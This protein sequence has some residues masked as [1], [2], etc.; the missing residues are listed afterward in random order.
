M[1]RCNC[2][3]LICLI[4]WSAWSQSAQ[5][6]Y[7][8]LHRRAWHRH[9]IRQ[10]ILNPNH[11]A[12]FPMAN[13]EDMSNL[14]ADSAKA[15]SEHWDVAYLRV[16]NIDVWLNQMATDDSKLKYLESPFQNK[17]WSNFYRNRARFFSHYGRY[18]SVSIDPVIDF[19]LGR[20]TGDGAYLFVNRR[21]IEVQ[22]NLDQRWSV[23]S[24]IVETQMNSPA[25]VNDYI[26]LYN[27]HP[28]AGFLKKYNS[29]FFKIAHAYDFLLAEGVI[30]YRISDHVRVQ[31]GHGRHF[32]GS[33]MRS[34]LLSDF[35]PPMFF[36]R[37]NTQFWKIHYQNIYAELSPTSQVEPFGVAAEEKKYFTAHYLSINLL[38]QW[39]VG[40]FESV[41][42]KRARQYEWQYLNPVILYRFVEQSL[43][44]P[45]NVF[46]G[47]HS[48]AVLFKKIE[49]YAQ[50]MLDEFVLKEQI[51]DNRGW[52]A[53]K[54]GFQFGLFYP[55]FF[56]IKG[57]DFRTEYNAVQPYTYSYR[58]S[59]SN[60]SHFHQA[61]AHPLGSNF[62]E[63]L[64]RI[65]WQLTSRW[66]MELQC[67]LF[68]KG[69]DTAGVNLGSN[70]L[71]PHTTRPFDY[72]HKLLQGQ[73]QK[74]SQG[75]LELRYQ[76]F[77]QAFLELRLY[78][79]WQRQPER[80]DQSWFSLGFRMNVDAQRLL[81]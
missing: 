6:K 68:T 50:V 59:L 14:Y 36:L 58:D 29:R 35:A 52:W 15:T 80:R 71:K 70:I 17:F 18:G 22:A 39:N 75:S 28:G 8:E 79:R 37:L 4:A 74:V 78:H 30:A 56:G 33:G 54:H 67:L 11:L 45:D 16:E 32:V 21:G 55:N 26:L 23:Y 81:F 49:C 38:P 66:A 9:Q 5:L 48:N 40:L 27:T 72:G 20:A 73:K 42:F 65:T 1:L 57:L 13:Q 76:L 3:I 7:N 2:L 64:S 44:S 77:H 43:G 10:G 53:N 31:F 69:I 12:I 25:Y 46:L 24:N 63:S 62:R 47:F 19:Q 51:I 60:Y 41:V 34:L 61:L